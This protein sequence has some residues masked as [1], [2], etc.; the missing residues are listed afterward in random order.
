MLTT[1][2]G[3]VNVVDTGALQKLAESLGGHVHVAAMPGDLVHPRATL[4]WWD[5]RGG[6]GLDAQH[7][8]VV[9]EAFVVGP[10]RVIGQDAS[11]GLIVLAEI[12]QRALSPGI[13][14]PGTAIAVLG[15][16]TR[17]LIEA[18]DTSE[19]PDAPRCARVSAPPQDPA[20]LVAIAYE[21]IVRSG[22]DQP[23]VVEQFLRH[24][25]ALGRNAAEDVIAAIHALV[26]RALAHAE[27][28]G[29]D[30]DDLA[31]WRRQVRVLGLLRDPTSITPGTS[32]RVD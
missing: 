14:D 27:H 32:P 4:A 7:E 3:H 18:L 13:N 19:D 20:A 25:E 6:A 8:Q 23:D 5:G 16:Q 24:L 26:Q 15:S 10:G 31:H 9:R 30:P 1:G 12:A 28:A 22:L 2:T 21:S 29:T 11:Y 17:L